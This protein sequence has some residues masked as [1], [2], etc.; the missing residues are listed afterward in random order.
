MF[1]RSG[2]QAASKDDAL[3]LRKWVV[4][5]NIAP[6]MQKNTIPLWRKAKKESGLLH[7]WVAQ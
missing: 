6:R 4:R 5:V 3:V 1:S 7:M 2:L